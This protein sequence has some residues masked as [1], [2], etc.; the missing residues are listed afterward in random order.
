MS[1]QLTCD[2]LDRRRR[3]VIDSARAL[4]IEQGFERTTLGDI[5]ERAGGSLSTVYKLFGNKDGLFEAVVSEKAASG[6]A[7]IREVMSTSGISPV[8]ALHLVA[9]RLHA[10]FLDPDV[11]A[12]V[13][14]V[15]G[16]SISDPV[17]ARDFSE[18][19]SSRTVVALESM[20]ARWQGEGVAMAYPPAMMAELFM[21]QFVSQIHKEAIHHGLNADH[22]PEH[23]RART[24]FFIRGAMLNSD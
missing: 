3:A 7:I 20:F 11:V 9:K 18:R 22:S 23:L 16:R 12:L 14:I 17:S 6:E 10:N 21:D 4:F 13:R 1:P 19:T 8:E 5:V 15:I 24:E 2:R